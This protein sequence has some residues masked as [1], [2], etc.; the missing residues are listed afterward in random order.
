MGGYIRLGNLEVYRMSVELSRKG[1][2][3]Y[4]KMNWE[5]KRIIGDQFIR[6][7]D[8][9]GANIAEG[10]GRFHYLDKIK[11]YYNARASLLETKHWVLLFK[12]REIISQE[13]F[14]D[15]IQGLN[16]LHQKLNV[17]IRSSRH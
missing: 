3:I 10:Y 11:F 15:I 16:N 12:E 17:F 8:S 1:W 13:I 2:K 14:Q 9:I 7:V 5:R 6:A 4:S